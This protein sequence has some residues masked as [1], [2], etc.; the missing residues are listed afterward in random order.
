MRPTI[1]ATAKLLSNMLS[2][3]DHASAIARFL[4][5][6]SG[7]ATSLRLVNEDDAAFLLE[8]RLDPTRNKNISATST[9]LGDQVEWIRNYLTRYNAGQE[10][11]FVIE[12]DGLPKGSIRFSDYDLATNSY[13]WG[14]WIIR[15]GT[16]PAAAFQSILLAYDL[17]FGPMQFRRARFDVRQANISVWKFHEKM[18]AK[19]S[20]EDELNRHYEYP[21]EEYPQARGWLVNFAQIGKTR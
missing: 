20:Y 18:G 4:A 12:V 8:L 21:A 6:R 5:E 15:P 1:S 9:V 13:S 11:Y 3:E 10:A 7:E 17:A 19:L 14:S 16:P 2:V